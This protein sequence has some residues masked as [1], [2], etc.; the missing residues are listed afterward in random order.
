MTLISI[1]EPIPSLVTLWEILSSNARSFPTDK[2]ILI[3]Q[4]M[5]DE[6]RRGTPAMSLADHFSRLRLPPPSDD[7]LE[8]IRLQ[9]WTRPGMGEGTVFAV[10]PDTP[11]WVK[12]FHLVDR[13][14][15]CIRAGTPYCLCSD[16]SLPPSERISFVY[17][18]ELGGGNF[19]I[20]MSRKPALRIES[21]IHKPQPVWLRRHGMVALHALE[22]VFLEEALRMETRKTLDMMAIHGG[23]AKVRGGKFQTRTRALGAESLLPRWR[24][25]RAN[26]EQGGSEP[27]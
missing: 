13:C 17:T 8:R 15:D 23:I 7:D 5:S 1:Q 21:H 11:L 16:L 6:Q 14:L 2:V 27:A 12:P 4:S 22:P 24:Q 26:G 19:Y 20:G 9:G 3:N 25:F 18:L 10:R